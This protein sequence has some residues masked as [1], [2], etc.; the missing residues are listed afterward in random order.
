ME[1]I[2]ALEKRIDELLMFAL[3]GNA[4]DLS[5]YMIKEQNETVKLIKQ[6]LTKEYAIL[7]DMIMG[8]NKIWLN[9]ELTLEQKI[10][11]YEVIIEHTNLFIIELKEEK[12]R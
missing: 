2:K 12:E 3:H 6:S 5:N 10:A 7:H 1:P 4:N 11:S 8:C 9:K